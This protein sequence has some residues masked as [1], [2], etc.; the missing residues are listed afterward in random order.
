MLV[1][2]QLG[3]LGA[4]V[5]KTKADPELATELEALGYST[6]WVGGSPGG[7][8]AREEALLAATRTLT[9]ATG[10]VNMWHD[11]AATVAR[12]YHRIEAAHPGRFLLGVGIGHPE[13]VSEYRTP[14]DKAV[15]Y[16]DELDAGGVPVE[17]RIL[18]ALGPR[19]LRLAAERSAGAHPYL[20]TPAHT[21]DA[22]AVIGPG[23][24]LV[25][26]HKVSLDPD[27]EHARRLAQAGVKIYLGLTNYRN[28]LFRYGFTPADF[29]PPGSD[30]LLDALVLRGEVSSVARGLQAHLEAGADQVAVQA[31]DEK[32][33]A[34][35]RAV[36]E[37][38]GL[39]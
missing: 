36:A 28:N 26:E 23:C 32:S 4:F 9:V 20:T 24:L 31:L 29:E 25:P 12:S 21:A 38:M 16:L 14:Y 27:P 11:D 39:T 35:F 22:R 33:Q 5:F 3:P 34:T 15:A 6:L 18:A 8:L 37:A 2:M 7:D 13:A 19:M 17:R 30:R 1:D 10:I